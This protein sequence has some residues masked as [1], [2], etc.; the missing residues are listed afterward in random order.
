MVSAG[1]EGVQLPSR[2]S[3]N[4]SYDSE[5]K[6]THGHRSEADPRLLPVPGGRAHARKRRLHC[7]Q[8]VYNNVRAS[9]WSVC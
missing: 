5:S 1:R 8:N 9:R 3:V 2:K 7:F 6:V 4:G